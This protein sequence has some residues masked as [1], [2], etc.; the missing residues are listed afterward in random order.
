M[1]L[2]AGPMVDISNECTELSN[3]E[4]VTLKFKQKKYV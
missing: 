4:N 1:H 3:D 2:G